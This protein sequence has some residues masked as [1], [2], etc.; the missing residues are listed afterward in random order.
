EELVVGSYYSTSATAEDGLV[1]RTIDELVG[2]GS[3]RTL[4]SG[5]A[6]G[7]A[8]SVS[9]SDI[10]VLYRTD[11]QA[12]PVIDALQRAGIPVQKRSHNRLRD[13]TGV[14]ELARELTLAGLGDDRTDLVTRIKQVGQ[15]LAE[16]YDTPTLDPDEAV[17]V[18]PEDV[19]AAVELVLPLAEECGDDLPR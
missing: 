9:F 7:Q 3:H 2:G 13:R 1:A 16:R 5:R 4:D 10:A 11:A 18:A 6:D 15:A 17:T 19:W 8:T 12:G 14:A